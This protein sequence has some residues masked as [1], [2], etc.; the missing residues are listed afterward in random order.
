MTDTSGRGSHS[1]DLEFLE[2]AQTCLLCNITVKV[3]RFNNRATKENP[4]DDADQFMLAVSQ[5]AGRRHTYAELSCALISGCG[6]ATS[7]RMKFR[8]AVK[9][10]R[11]T[12]GGGFRVIRH[13]GPC[14]TGVSTDGRVVPWRYSRWSNAGRREKRWTGC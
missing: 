11:C 13:G 2:P 10:T 7:R 3:Y 5:I 14:R 12:L 4:L 9:I 1:G 8:K 6:T